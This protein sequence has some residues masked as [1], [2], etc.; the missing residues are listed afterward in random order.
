VLTGAIDEATSFGANDFRN[1]VPRFAPEARQTNRALVDVLAWLLAAAVE[2]SHEDPKEIEAA[3]SSV[4]IQGARY[5]ADRQML[6][7]R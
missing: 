6:V 1:M 4:P 2:L 3:V 7:G 5:S